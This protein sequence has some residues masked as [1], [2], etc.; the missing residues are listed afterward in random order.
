MSTDFEAVDV[1]HDLHTLALTL[2]GEDVRRYA[3]VARMPGG[4]F[5]S[6]DDARKEGLPGQI[7][8]GNMSLAL[9][10]RLIAESFPGAT[11]KKLSATFRGL[12]HPGRALEVRGVVTEKHCTDHGDLVECDLVLES[13]E[14]DRWVTGTAT[15]QFPARS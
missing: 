6:D 10:S 1:G 4:R 15:V 11:L 12:V 2:T 9:F 5:M 7:V 3:V 8:P 13:A 14:G